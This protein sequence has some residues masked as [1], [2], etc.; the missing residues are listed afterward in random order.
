MRKLKRKPVKTKKLHTS[1]YLLQRHRDYLNSVCELQGISMTACIAA[2]IE[3]S[4]PKL[5]NE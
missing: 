3:K 1:I 4:M 5:Y 2:L